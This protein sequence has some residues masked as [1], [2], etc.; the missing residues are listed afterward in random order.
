MYGSLRF[1]LLLLAVLCPLVR[2]MQAQL[3]WE[4]REVTLRPIPGERAASAEFK[5]TNAGTKEVSVTKVDTSCGCT[6]A[7]LEPQTYR[8]QESGALKVAFAFEGRVGWQHKSIAVQTTD[9]VAPVTFLTL[10]VL[11]PE[12][13]QLSE[14]NVVWKFGDSPAAKT[15]HI[16]VMNHAFSVTGASCQDEKFRCDLR[17]LEA[18]KSYEVTITPTSTTQADS[19]FVQLKTDQPDQPAI[20]LQ[21][22]VSDP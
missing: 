8:A 22:S 17:T 3:R 11:I 9:S 4:Q 5:F 18:G 7:K 15:V 1:T 2:P 13:I 16:E 10:H 19:A 21:V 12:A 6:T 20:H 14:R